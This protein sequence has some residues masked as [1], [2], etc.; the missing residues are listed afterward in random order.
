ML[1]HTLRNCGVKGKVALWLAAFLDPQTRKH[2]VG[3]EGR[4]SPVFPVV[5]GVPQ[6][7]VLGPILF[8]FFVSDCPVGQPSYVDNFC[9]RHSAVK[10]PELE[11]LLQAD[12]DAFVDWAVSK[13][14]VIAPTKCSIT[15]IIMS[16][17]MPVTLMPY[18]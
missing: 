13:R 11:E 12:V 8:N 15:L 18:F 16:L 17:N 2:S 14:L 6:G 4:V 7:S 1:L 9:I 5:S 10:V 3:V